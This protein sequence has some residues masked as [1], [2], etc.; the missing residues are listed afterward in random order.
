MYSHREQVSEAI[1]GPID[2]VFAFLDDHARL[3]S[4]MSKRSWM[5]GG[6][7]METTMDAARGQAVGSLI[8]VRGRAFGVALALDETVVEREPPLRKTWETSGEPRLLVIGR[9]KMGFA[10]TAGSPVGLRVQIDY[11]LPAGALRW[12]AML[13]GPWYARWCVRRVAEDTARAFRKW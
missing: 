12:L 6:G 11:D 13:F 7:K 5:M 4:H 3:T 9:Y 1:T 10:L 2:R 8:S